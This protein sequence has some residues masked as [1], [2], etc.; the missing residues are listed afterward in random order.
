MDSQFIAN[1]LAK[2]SGLPT[3]PFRAHQQISS[4]SDAIQRLKECESYV[5]FWNILLT[6]SVVFLIILLIIKKELFA[7]S[8]TALELRLLAIIYCKNN[9]DRS[10]RRL[11][12]LKYNYFTDINS[13]LINH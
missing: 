6:V 3:H 1:C 12:S 7:N 9:I 8:Q 13:Q 2:A 11:K 10:W 5:E 4:A